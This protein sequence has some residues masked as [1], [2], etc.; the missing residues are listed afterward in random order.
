MEKSAV[1]EKNS[2]ILSGKQIR[3]NI[4]RVAVITCLGRAI[5]LLKD[6]FLATFLGVG[7]QAD[8]FFLAFRIPNMLRTT[9]AEGSIPGALVPVSS[10]LLRHGQG[11]RVRGLLSLVMASLFFVGLALWGIVLLW[12]ERVVALVASGLEPAR[13]AMAADFLKIMFPFL[14]IISMCTATGS[15]LQSANHF[16]IQ[17]AGPPVLNIVWMAALIVALHLKLPVKFMCFSVLFAGASKLIIRWSVLKNKH[18]LPGLPTKDTLKDLALVAARFAPLGL[19]IFFSMTKILV[20]TQLGSFLPIGQITLMH[21]AFRV[22]NLPLYTISSPI[23]STILPQVSKVSA[24]HP[25]RVTFYLFE[26]L[27]L[28]AWST[29]PVSVLIILGSNN[30]MSFVAS[31]R[32]TPEQ[33]KIG[34]QLLAILASGLFFEVLNKVL[35]NVFYAKGDTK[36]PT[37]IWGLSVT[38]TSVFSIV[39]VFCFGWNAHGIMLSTVLAWVVEAVLKISVLALKHDVKLPKSCLSKF[40][41]T[42][43]AQAFTAGAAVTVLAKIFGLIFATSLIFSGRN[44]LALVPFIMALVTFYILFWTLRKLKTFRSSRSYFFD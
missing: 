19:G 4:F 5:G 20:E 7:A 17:A 15:I 9:F 14:I 8:A 25:Q 36:T 32:A 37:A 1:A 28:V 26:T 41:I 10:K 42:F 40:S 44:I 18:L 16:T 21:L 30:I 3:K 35:R 24:T 11:Q 38:V 2:K 29:I 34:A 39:A 13:L 23:A 33:I 6:T 12:P 31:S 27:K 22:F 43:A